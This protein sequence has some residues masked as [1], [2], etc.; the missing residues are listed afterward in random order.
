MLERKTY[1]DSNIKFVQIMLA[2]FSTSLNQMGGGGGG[3]LV[4]SP[5]EAGYRE[6]IITL[7]H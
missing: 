3:G 6:T 2:M 5:K 4:G 7:C 1:A